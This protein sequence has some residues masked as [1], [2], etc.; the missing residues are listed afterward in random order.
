MEK[1]RKRQ[2]SR[3]FKERAVAMSYERANIKELSVELGVSE[4]RLYKWRSQYR[5]HGEISFPGH[6]IERLSEEGRKLKETEKENR[7][8]KLELEILKKAIAI[9]SQTDRSC[10]HS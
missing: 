9:F 1:K 10:I 5:L 4:E 3:D 7:R 8:L 6:G 2:Y